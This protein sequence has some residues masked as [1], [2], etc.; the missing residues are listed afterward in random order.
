MTSGG[1]EN[2]KVG[3][4]SAPASSLHPDR[5]NPITRPQE[6][7]ILGRFDAIV[8]EFRSRVAIQDSIGRVTYGQLAIFAD[9]IAAAV[10]AAV[11]GAFG[12]I[13]L[14]LPPHPTAPP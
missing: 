2:G 6:N 3:W 5:P 14:L 13:A 9:R 8:R 4:F 11:Q 12:P 7:S 10:T 1:R